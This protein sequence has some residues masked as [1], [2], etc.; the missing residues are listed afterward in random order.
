MNAERILSDDVSSTRDYQRIAS[1]LAYVDA[2]FLDQPSLTEIAEHTGLS[3]FHFQRLFTRW[4]GISPKKFLKHLT[5]ERAKRSLE[6][7]ASVLDATYDAG[8]SGPGRLHD[9]F[10]TSEAVT[11]GEYKA[12]GQGMTIRYGFHPSP[13]GECLLMVTDRG[14]CGLAFV[15]ADETREDTLRYLSSGWENARIVEAPTETGVLIDRMFAPARKNASSSDAPL[16]VLLRG[17]EFQTRVWQ[18]LLTIPP[19][20]LATYDDIARRLGYKSNAARAVGRANATN[21]ISY[22][23]PC[24]R[25]IRKTGA[26]GG[27]RWGNARKLAMIGWEAAQAEQAA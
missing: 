20:S 5:L 19:G 14:I 6:S 3:E 10:V 11:P 1:A 27:Y 18:A 8:L 17:T 24:H 26:L 12:R 13:F 22:L 15:D 4:V 25:V 9:L 21:M 7:S 23:V 16:R 2:H